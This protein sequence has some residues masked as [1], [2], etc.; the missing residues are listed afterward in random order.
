MLA[1]EIQRAAS[2]RVDLGDELF[3]QRYQ[4]RRKSDNLA[5]MAAV[6]TFKRLFA[7]QSLPL[8]WLRNEGMR[9]LGG[10]APVKRRIVR[11]AMGFLDR[12]LALFL[13]GSPVE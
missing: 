5:M 9:H 8:I 11:H 1:E 12:S 2:G 3:L 7:S 13:T 4:R 6:E 10:S